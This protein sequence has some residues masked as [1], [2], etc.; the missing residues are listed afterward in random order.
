[1]VESRATLVDPRNK[2]SDTERPRHAAETSERMESVSRQMGKEAKNSWLGSSRADVR[3]SL[4]P[5]LEGI[6]ADCLSA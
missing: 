6:I 3:G 5:K 2:E 4:L 1:M